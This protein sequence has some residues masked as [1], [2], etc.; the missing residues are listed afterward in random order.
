[1]QDSDKIAIKAGINAMKDLLNDVEIEIHKDIGIYELTNDEEV[2]S[3]REAILIDAEWITRSYEGEEE[4][5]REIIERMHQYI[6]AVEEDLFADTCAGDPN[7][8]QKAL[9]EHLPSDRR[10]EVF[11]TVGKALSK[12]CFD[13]YQTKQTGFLAAQTG[14]STENVFAGLEDLDFD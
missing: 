5:K 6:K 14:V 3:M 12:K 10:A 4:R 9:D 2:L 1:M 8:V 13:T 11:L 7:S